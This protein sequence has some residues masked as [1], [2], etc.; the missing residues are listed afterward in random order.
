M[1]R[2]RGGGQAG[3]N[4]GPWLVPE[5]PYAGNQ[6]STMTY[7]NVEPQ[8]SFP[9]LEREVLAFWDGDATFEASVAAR[10]PNRRY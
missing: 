9:A 8:P 6:E 2:R 4:R 3:W 7:P 5:E 10:D 1:A